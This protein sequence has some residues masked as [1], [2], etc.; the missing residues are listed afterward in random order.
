MKCIFSF[1]LLLFSTFFFSTE[2]PL[3]YIENKGQW[4]SNIL[5]KSFVPSGELYLENDRL[6]YVFYDQQK[7]RELHHQQCTH[8]EAMH[9]CVDQKIDTHAFSV[10]FINGQMAVTN[11]WDGTY[12]NKACQ[13]GVYGWKIK[14][15]GGSANQILTGNVTLFR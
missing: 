8:N 15:H 13:I 7:Q 11:G 4:E 14:Y 12:K 5:F 9:A 3:E 2:K 1:F 6:S 10:H